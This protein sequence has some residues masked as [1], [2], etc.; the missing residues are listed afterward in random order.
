MSGVH[1]AIAAEITRKGLTG[2]AALAE[3][4]QDKM[5]KETGR[6]IHSSSVSA[7]KTAGDKNEYLGK[8]AKDAT[9]GK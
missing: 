4:S 7:G 2:S 8:N 1:R 3:F 9:P 6:T 5:R